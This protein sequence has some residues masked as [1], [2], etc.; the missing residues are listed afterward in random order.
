MAEQHIDPLESAMPRKVQSISRLLFSMLLTFVVVLLGVSYLE[1]KMTP[2]QEFELSDFRIAYTDQLTDTT[3]PEAAFEPAPPMGYSYYLGAPGEY[4]V[5][6]TEF[7]ASTANLNDLALLVPRARDR[8]SIFLNGRQIGFETIKST[9]LDASYFGPRYYSLPQKHLLEG[10]NTLDIY[11]YG[12]RIKPRLYGAFVGDRTPLTNSFKWRYFLVTDMF[13]VINGIGVFMAMFALGVGL[14]SVTQRREY[15]ALALALFF[16]VSRNLYYSLPMKDLP[17]AVQGLF[18]SVVTFGLLLSIAAFV[19]AWTKGDAR[20]YRRLALIFAAYV[21]TSFAI[22]LINNDYANNFYLL[23]GLP[24]IFLVMVWVGYRLLKARQLTIPVMIGFSICFAAGF[25]DMMSA[26]LIIKNLEWWPL[27]TSM[28]YTPGATLVVALGLIYSLS[29]QTIDLQ[30][31]EREQRTFLARE[32]A[33]RE[34]E[35]AA[36]YARTREQEK[37][38]A[39]GQ[40][41]QRIMQDMHDGI[42]SQLLALQLRIKQEN[43][44]ATDISSELNTSLNDLRLIVDSLD[45]EMDDVAMALGAFRARVQPQLS[46]AGVT[47]DWE[48]TINEQIGGFGPKSVLHIYRIM[49][50]A[51]TNA[52]RHAQMTQL[53]IA[54]SVEPATDDMPKGV[55]NIRILDNGIGMSEEA[56][57]SRRGVRNMHRRAEALRGSLSIKDTKPGTEIDVIIPLREG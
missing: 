43:L 26:I 11:V 20:T 10:R 28:P 14:V 56:R 47:L 1:S 4:V 39:I 30:I 17:V 57:Q 41:R 37:E 52:L 25:V 6:R 55:L 32:L 42:G 46:A 27:L 29:K 49:Q 18:F 3:L 8:V 24:I 35:L 40:E 12:Y 7:S 44:A 33:A 23:V 38:A 51:V 9:D 53:K 15:L 31:A 22:D 5:L 48:M 34:Q 21:V 45:T 13:S 50:E 16:M 2:P 36:S 19:N 54:M